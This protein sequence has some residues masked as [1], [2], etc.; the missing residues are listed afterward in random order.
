MAARCLIIFDSFRSKSRR[1]S[2]LKEYEGLLTEEAGISH[3]IML[4][5][6]NNGYMNRGVGSSLLTNVKSIV[7]L[8]TVW[9]LRV[10]CISRI[11]LQVTVA[12]LSDWSRKGTEKPAC[13][14]SNA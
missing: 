5:N 6:L 12:K 1:R 2:Y 11:S 8:L 10:H 9:T 4:A 7:P 14:H 13:I 3:C